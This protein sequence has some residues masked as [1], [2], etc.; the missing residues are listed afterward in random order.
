[1]AHQGNSI[2]HVLNVIESES[3]LGAGLHAAGLQ[4]AA[5]G[6]NGH[7]LQAEIAEDVVDGA[8]KACSISQQ[9]DHRSDAP[10]HAQHGDS[11]PPAVVAHRGK[12][13]VGHNLDT[14]P[15]FVLLAS[16]RAIIA[17]FRSGYTPPTIPG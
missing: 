9:D 16:T 8:S 13:L 14:F 10:G 6:K 3:C 4:G 1:M 2:L 15:S 7:H 12:G 11:R 17:A 5:S